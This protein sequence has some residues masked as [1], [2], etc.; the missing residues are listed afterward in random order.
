MRLSRSLAALVTIGC[1]AS[2]AAAGPAA[3]RTPASHGLQPAKSQALRTLGG[4]LMGLRVD[5]FILT[6][7]SDVASAD[8]TA[9]LPTIT[10]DVTAL[11]A[12]NATLRAE[13]TLAGVQADAASLAG[14]HVGDFVLPQARVVAAAD[15]MGASA[16]KASAA[17]PRLQAAITAAQTA[18]RDVTAANAALTDYVAQVA[19]ATSDAGAVHDSA[20]ALISGSAGNAAAFTADAKQVGKSGAELRTAARD[21]RTIAR[22]VRAR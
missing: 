8:K 5:A 15:E 22:T 1:A 18:G 14:Y 11:T 13:T 10:A 4:D 6:C 19:A 21:A 17:Q 3:A 16:A 2:V 12:L 7:D 9:L 20:I